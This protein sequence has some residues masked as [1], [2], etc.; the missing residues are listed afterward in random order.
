MSRGDAFRTGNRQGGDSQDASG[1]KRGQAD[2]Q[3]ESRS[4]STGVSVVS[5]AWLNASFRGCRADEQPKCT[6]CVH[7]VTIGV[8]MGDLENSGA[9]SLVA[10][11][12]RPSPG[13][14]ID[15]AGRAGLVVR[16][17]SEYVG[18]GGRCSGCTPVR[19]RVGSP[20]R[21]SDTAVKLLC[22]NDT[23]ISR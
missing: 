4:P 1:R 6:L 19:S 2:A 23:S 22:N 3:D 7:S 18:T 17:S 8:R 12:R 11:R 10:S 5:P 21:K 14:S 20:L 15:M 13:G 9:K 16:R